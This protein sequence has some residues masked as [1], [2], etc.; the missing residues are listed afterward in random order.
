MSELLF[1]NDKLKHIHDISV[2]VI[3]LNVFWQEI[4]HK[5]ALKTLRIYTIVKLALI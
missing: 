3:T 5:N 2:I 4:K 1:S